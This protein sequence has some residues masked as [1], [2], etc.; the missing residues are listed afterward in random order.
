M[1]FNIRKAFS[2]IFPTSYATTS[3]AVRLP[4]RLGHRRSGAG[5]C[6]GAPLPCRRTVLDV[7]RRAPVLPLRGADAPHPSPCAAY[8]DGPQDWH[9]PRGGSSEPG[10]G[11][12]LGAGDP[13][14]PGIL[15]GVPAHDYEEE[16]STTFLLAH[17]ALR[18]GPRHLPYLPYSRSGRSSRSG[19]LPRHR[20]RSP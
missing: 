18:S 9:G 5:P 15:R 4:G 2:L 8:L 14:R 16:R 7:A 17:Y 20:A 1:F 3:G 6:P 10:H 13:T 19:R 11:S 12:V